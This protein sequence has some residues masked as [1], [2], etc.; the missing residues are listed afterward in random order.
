MKIQLV[1]MIHGVKR[2][3]A[4]GIGTDDRKEFIAWA[5]YAGIELQQVPGSS[6]QLVVLST[7]HQERLFDLTWVTPV[8]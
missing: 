2:G 5:T 7:N 4:A 1:P 8:E 6:S 3:S